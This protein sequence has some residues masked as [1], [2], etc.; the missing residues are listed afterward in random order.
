[1]KHGKRGTENIQVTGLWFRLFT[2]LVS[3]WQCKR[4]TTAKGWFSRD[5]FLFGVTLINSTKA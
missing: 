3:D 1:M 2:K 5:V 4:V